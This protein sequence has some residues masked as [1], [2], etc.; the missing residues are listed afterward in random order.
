MGFL[1]K[2]LIIF[3]NSLLLRHPK[4]CYHVHKSSALDTNSLHRC[5]FQMLEQHLQGTY[6]FPSHS[7]NRIALHNP[8]AWRR[9]CIRCFAG[10]GSVRTVPSSVREPRH[11]GWPLQLSVGHNNRRPWVHLYLRQRKPSCAGKRGMEFGDR[12][13][14]NGTLTIQRWSLRPS[15]YSAFIVESFEQCALKKWQ[16]FARIRKMYCLR[17]HE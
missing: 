6:R 8:D 5:I 13:F 11:C 3:L 2:F 12:W 9:V 10:A 4:I 14:S 7:L 15:R 16:Y 17:L 1:G